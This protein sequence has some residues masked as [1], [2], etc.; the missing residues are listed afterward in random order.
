LGP[1]G[2]TSFLGGVAFGLESHFEDAFATTA[3]ADHLCLA[4][5]V[6]PELLQ[7][8]NSALLIIVKII[9]TAYTPAL[10]HGK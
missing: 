2:I 8:L 5:S 4:H 1:I 7:L 6:T 3:S 9:K 10:P